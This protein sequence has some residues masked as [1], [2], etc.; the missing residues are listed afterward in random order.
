MAED[1]AC[2]GVEECHPYREFEGSSP[3]YNYKNIQ[4]PRA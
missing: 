3:Q 2:K 4:V 1:H